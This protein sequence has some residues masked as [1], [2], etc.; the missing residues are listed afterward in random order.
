MVTR[1]IK[2]AFL[3]GAGDSVVGQV[4]KANE[5]NCG[6]SKTVNG[7][8]FVVCD[9][10]GG[11]VGGATA[12]RIAVDSILSFISQ[13]VYED[14]RIALDSALKF[15]NT[16]IMGAAAQDPSLK[17]MGTTACIVLV[18]S[19]N[20]WIA[21]VGDSRI[22]LYSEQEKY[23]YRITKDHSLVQGLVD[24]GELDD[25]EAE[26]HPQK[27][28]I[29]RALGTKQD[30]QPEV[31]QVPVRAQVGDTFLICSDGLSGM[32]DDNQ[33]EAI[34]REDRSLEDKVQK[35]I[36][37]ANT[38]DKGK[39][40]ITV[41]LI[42]VL[43]SPDNVSVHPDFNPK[44]RST[45]TT[46][47]TKEITRPAQVEAPRP[48]AKRKKNK[49]IPVLLYSALGVFLF[50]ASVGILFFTTDIFRGR[51][52]ATRDISE[53]I[54]TPSTISEISEEDAEKAADEALKGITDENE[55]IARSLKA[56]EEQK[57]SAESAK[58]QACTFASKAVLA[59]KKAE[60][61]RDDAK[62]APNAA[63]ANAAA[64][65]AQNAVDEAKD[66]LQKTR[67][68]KT[69][70]YNAQ[71]R[72]NSHAN[73]AERV[74]RNTEGAQKARTAANSAK[75]AYEKAEQAYEDANTAYSAATTAYNEAVM[76]AEK[77]KVAE[78]RKNAMTQANEAHNLASTAKS[79][80]EKAAQKAHEVLE[81]VKNIQTEADKTAVIAAANAA[82]DAANDA[83][84]QAKGAQTKSNQALSNAQKVD[85]PEAT[86]KATAA[87]E[88]AA[89]ALEKANQAIKDAND[90]TTQ[91]QN[92][93][94]QQP[95]TPPLFDEETLEEEPVD[96]LG[97]T[98]KK[99][100]TI[101]YP[102]KLWVGASR[103]CNFDAGIFTLQQF[104]C[105]KALPLTW[106]S[107][108]DTIV[109]PKRDD[110]KGTV[111]LVRK[112]VGNAEV[113][114]VD[115]NKDTIYIINVRIEK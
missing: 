91:A 98:K 40:N 108:N 90:A 80:A 100:I 59:Q 66:Y 102:S 1:Y 23:L 11:H 6:Y 87:L 109:I 12:S 35:L 89:A 27:N 93:P 34:L 92:M 57:A 72:A 45:G 42:Q 103:E 106:S 83:Q 9:G 95:S 33:I 39:D 76:A 7:E 8:L 48:K 97:A 61:A 46:T 50:V 47:T 65:T 3:H 26:H 112:K 38:P 62:N 88:L 36:D 4:R 32:L 113:Y 19:Q 52:E 114:G 20:I 71:G 82:L 70:A 60:E 68:E 53:V 79:S 17:G 30:V 69:N 29:L 104:S 86:T 63:A 96:M 67:D 99:P 94:I 22:Y 58:N 85:A 84:K 18:D 24:K 31:D 43:S 28:I 10:M 77:A 55:K 107:S 78:D 37:N 13:Q 51:G 110:K 14:K 105:A 44:W 25:R 15:A 54:A 73:A 101:D 16:Q 111:G 56:A 115:T 81:A 21:H 41:Q 5:D 75:Q 49:T 2:D 64:K 74:N